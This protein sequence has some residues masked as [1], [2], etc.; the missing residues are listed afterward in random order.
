[1]LSKG[2]RPRRCPSAVKP[3]RYVLA[4]PGIDPKPHGSRCVV[5]KASRPRICLGAVLPGI[6]VQTRHGSAKEHRERFVMVP[7]GSGAGIPESSGVRGRARGL[8]V[9]CSDWTR[10]VPSSRVRGARL[11]LTAERNAKRGTRRRREGT[12]APVP[13]FSIDVRWEGAGL[14]LVLIAHIYIH[15]KTALGIK[16]LRVLRYAR[17]INEHRRATATVQ[18]PSRAHRYARRERHM[19]V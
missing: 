4:R 3:W 6:H 14:F 9:A 18:P 11:C 13:Q 17:R 8:S 10:G 19:A 15:P 16:P 12:G 1:M 5:S 7:E 2:S